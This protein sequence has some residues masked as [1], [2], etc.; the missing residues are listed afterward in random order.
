MPLFITAPS[1]KRRKSSKRRIDVERSQSHQCTFVKSSRVLIVGDIKAKLDQSSDLSDLP[2]IVREMTDAHKP[3]RVPVRYKLSLTISRLSLSRDRALR[4]WLLTHARKLKGRSADS[5]GRE[6][7]T[8]SVFD[9]SDCPR[10][11][12]LV[13]TREPMKSTSASFREMRAGSA[14]GLNTGSKPSRTRRIDGL[15]SRE[16][17]DRSEAE[18]C[19]IVPLKRGLESDDQYARRSER[20]ERDRYRRSNFDD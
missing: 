11:H 4:E 10:Q 5:S 1:H 19:G 16:E 12:L 3:E 7:Y 18:S 15:P 2:D 13:Q 14:Y 8:F 6:C 9:A 20:H 17:I